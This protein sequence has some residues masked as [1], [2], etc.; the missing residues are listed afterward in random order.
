MLGSMTIPRIPFGR[1]G[2]TSSRVVFGAV[3]LSGATPAESNA[4]LELLLE[5]G[6]N[7][8][9]TAAS[10]GDSEDQL[11]PWLAEHR[12]AFFLATKT[13]DRSRAAARDSIHRSLERMDVASVDLIQLHNLVHPGEW[14]QAL[15]PGGALEAVLEARDEGLV[16]FV[17]VTGHGLTVAHQHRRALDVFP[18]DSVLAP[19]NPVALRDPMYG[20]DF[21]ALARVCAERNVALQTIKAI[22]RG[23]WGSSR[24]DSGDLVRASHRPRRDRRRRCVRP[25]S[26]E[27]VPE[28]G[29]RPGAS[30]ARPRRR[31]ALLR[32]TRPGSAR[33][34]CRTSS[35]DAA[36]RLLTT[37]RIRS[38]VGTEAAR[39]FTD[40][41]DW[42]ESNGPLLKSYLQPASDSAVRDRL[43]AA[44]LARADDRVAD[45]G[46]AIP[47]LEGRTVRRDVAVAGD[48]GEQVVDLV[49]EGVLPADDVPVRPP[50][51]PEGVVCLADEDRAEPIRRRRECWSSLSRSR[52]KASDPFEPLISQLNAFR[53]PT[54]KR[55]ASIVPTRRSSNSTAASNASSTSRPA[56]NVRIEAETD[57]ISPTR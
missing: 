46:R 19:C 29:R 48:R 10:Y 53:R 17:G 47:V 5:H 8:I 39:I 25:R 54:A 1:T 43:P 13:G 26:R 15:G 27:R 3:A 6:V 36:L 55:V 18:F 21:E 9:D 56:M 33:R 28:H 45:L 32:P 37:T 22:T 38:R 30:S 14:E 12:D 2:H 16:R 4:V 41:A 42:I 7:H 34:A 20:P 49:D 35:H 51:L 57:A 44:G 24:S 31:R 50:P 52:S 11:R 23:P 40:L